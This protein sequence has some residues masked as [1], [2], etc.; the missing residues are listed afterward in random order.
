MPGAAGQEW[1]ADRQDSHRLH[2]R[3]FDYTRALDAGLA[4][5]GTPAGGSSY[6]AVDCCTGL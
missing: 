1:L 4:A 3:A 5:G 6:R 2:G